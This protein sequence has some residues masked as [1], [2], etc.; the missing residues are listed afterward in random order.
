MADTRNAAPAGAA[1]KG[2]PIVFEGVTKAYGD[3]TVLHGIDLSIAPGEF[4]ALLGPSGCGKT[5]MLRCLAGLEQPTS[6]RILVGGDDVSPVPADRPPTCN[7]ALPRPVETAF[8]YRQPT[9]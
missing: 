1:Q 6:G 8:Q 7:P 5:T 9:G 3:T 2:T 4:V